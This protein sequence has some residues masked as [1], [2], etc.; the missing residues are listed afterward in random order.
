MTGTTT[1]PWG[2]PAMHLRTT[3]LSSLAL[4]AAAAF[5]TT[6]ALADDVPNINY[7]LWETTSVATIESEA[8]SLPPTT[9]TTSSCVTKEDA[10]KGHAFMDGHENCEILEQSVTRTSVKKTMVCNQPQ[11]GEMKMSLF[12]EYDGDTM[13]GQIEGEMESPMG[14][15]TMHIEM[16]GKR[17]GDC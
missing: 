6:P 16:K 13:T 7:G 1:V 8:M 11:A 3:L 12:M 15:M 2:E 9:D 4:L 14:K 17:I 10:E 5:A